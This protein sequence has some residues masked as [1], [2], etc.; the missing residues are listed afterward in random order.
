M[1]GPEEEYEEFKF[2]GRVLEIINSH[3]SSD[4]DTP[5]FLCYTSHIVHE[6]LQV[7]QA[8]DLST[9]GMFYCSAHNLLYCC[10]QVPNTT[11]Q[12]FDFIGSSAVGDFQY[13]RQ[14]Y[15]SM[16]CKYF[17]IN[18]QSIFIIKSTLHLQISFI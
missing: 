4:A 16:V 10:A 18:T 3:D 17:I 12:H 5:L 11:W 6:P 9:A 1:T 13:H 7:S 8:H 15:H 14:T 2:K